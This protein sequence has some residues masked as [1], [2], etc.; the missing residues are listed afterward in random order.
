MM[1]SVIF[2]LLKSRRRRN[3]GAV[4]LCAQIVSS[5]SDSSFRPRTNPV[6]WSK[7][8][9]L[10]LQEIREKVLGEINF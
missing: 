6:E 1:I 9:V 4:P 10:S 8:Q 3:M 7:S 2:W 5:S